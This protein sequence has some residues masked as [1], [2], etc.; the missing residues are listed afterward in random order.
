MAA[1]T[2]GNGKVVF[3]GTTEATLVAAPSTGARVVR[4]VSLFNRDS[5]SR[6]LTL[7]VDDGTDYDIITITVAAGTTHVYDGTINLTTAD[8]LKVVA[9]ATA[10]TTEPVA[11]AS[12]AD[13]S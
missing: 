9:D 7:R 8:T 5:V 3:T 6:D 4:S 2:P 11:F 12:F 10:A 13:I 1:F